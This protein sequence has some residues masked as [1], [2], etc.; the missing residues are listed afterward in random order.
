ML[1]RFTAHATAVNG[2]IAT[3]V[4]LWDRDRDVLVTLTDY[5]NNVVGQIAEADT[6][7][8]LAD[9]P[10]SRKVMEERVAIV[11]R[12]SDPGA[13]PQEARIL[14]EEGYETMLM[15]PLVSRGEPIG[16]MELADVSDRSW[17]DEMEFF[18]A[19]T[20]VVAAAVHNAV[21]H[22][23]F[24]RA[25]ERYRVLVEHLPMVTYVDAAGSGDPV[26]VSPQ[27]GE[28]IG[29]PVEEWLDSEDGWTKRIHPDDIA[30]AAAYRTTIETGEPFS[31]TYRVRGADG[32]LRWF[33]DEAVAVRDEAG[34]PRLIQ[35][36]IFDVTRQKEAENAL[37]A[38]EARF[39]EMLENVRLAAVVT[40]LDGRITF[41][42][43]YLAELSGW[44]QDELLGRLWTDTFTPPDEIDLEQRG[45]RAMERGTVIP[46]YESSLITKSGERRLFSWNNTLLRD[47]TGRW[48]VRP[49]W[50]RTSPTA[51]APSRSWSAWPSTTR[52]PACPTGFCSVSTWRWR[53]PVRSA[54]AAVWP[55][56][57]STWTTSSW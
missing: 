3:A 49:P 45:L 11:V 1:R 44:W 6:E 21:L 32:Q 26:Y 27:I 40:D 23:E 8:P 7:Y 48:S 39:R 28:L 42:N 57:T 41:C 9:Y 2:T 56:S 4:S 14:R 34:T 25:E 35:G 15:M 47:A 30:V 10:Q 13:D 54:P 5:R 22:D 31:A 43:D 12:A 19:L 52:L 18:R 36:V 16:L 33:H 37:Q 55:C 46:H 24:R 17:D 38:S 20:D 50:A 53:W 51:A 29:V